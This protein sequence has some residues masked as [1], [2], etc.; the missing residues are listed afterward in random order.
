[1]PATVEKVN[2]KALE[3]AEL[4]TAME[5]DRSRWFRTTKAMYWNQ[6]EVLWPHRRIGDAFMVGECWSM[7]YYA[8]FKQVG[9]TYWAR[10]MTTSEFEK[11]FAGKGPR[12]A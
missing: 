8:T 11:E 10:Y 12:K 9:T 7:G 4:W 2:W 3:W 1:M 6:L 5:K